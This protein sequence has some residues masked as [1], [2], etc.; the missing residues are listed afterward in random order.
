MVVPWTA[1]VSCPVGGRHVDKE[2]RDGGRVGERLEISRGCDG[3]SHLIRR[4]FDGKNS[5]AP[6]Y[7]VAR[8]LLSTSSSKKCASRPL[9]N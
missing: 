2:I 8:L 5:D 1:V 4:F 9:R 6:E 3:L 7:R